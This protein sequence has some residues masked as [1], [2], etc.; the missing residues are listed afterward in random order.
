[1]PQIYTCGTSCYFCI[2]VNVITISAVTLMYICF[3]STKLLG[4]FV[5]TY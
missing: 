2:I 1:M 3:I 4:I 5:S